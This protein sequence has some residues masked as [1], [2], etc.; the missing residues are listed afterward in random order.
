M[1]KI[2][3]IVVISVFTG[4]CAANKS[5]TDIIPKPASKTKSIAVKDSAKQLGNSVSA[6]TIKKVWSHDIGSSY[7]DDNSGFQLASV[8]SNIIAS[9][10]SGK[11]AVVNQETGKVVW[12]TSVKSKLLAGPGV[13]DGNVY[14]ST[15]KGVVIALGQLNGKELWR[16][17][18]SSEVL[19]APVSTKGV[20]VVRSS[21]GRITGLSSVDGKPKWSLQRELPRLS[22]RGESQTLLSDSV[23]V[24]G[25]PSGNLL[26]IDAVQGSAL[27][28]IPITFA[29]GSNALERINDIYA[30]P[31]ISK[32]LL[33]TATYQGEIVAI[34]IPSKQRVW[35]APISSYRKLTTDGIVV[36]AVDDQS[37]VIAMDANTG[38]IRWETS[39]LANTEL[40]GSYFL[41][42]EL[43]AFDND[44]KAF[45]L[46][47]LT[48]KITAE[49]TVNSGSVIGEPISYNDGFAFLTGNGEITRYTK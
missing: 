22:L 44:G 37:N 8:N 35:S 25:L 16:F 43:L 3:F 26:A 19:S 20:V 7:G 2:A 18:A 28:D 32:D 42:G 46:N 1:R 38:K 47:S 17:Q 34:H 6:S 11:V 15:D 49:Y 45:Q 30:A 21:D 36:V 27:W 13:G 10:R 40:A 31:I 41:N 23:A 24:I 33:Y 39:L 48:G 14:V 9:S 12:K 5:F 29:S 4:A